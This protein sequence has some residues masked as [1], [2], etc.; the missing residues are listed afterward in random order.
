MNVKKLCEELHIKVL[1]CYEK[2]FALAM[3]E[4]EEKGTF[5]AED[6][7][8]YDVI[9]KYGIFEK[10]KN[11]LLKAA[12][13]IRKNKELLRF[14]YLLKHVLR[15][16]G[17]FDE[18]LQM[19]FPEND[20]E[21]LAFNFASLFSV[22]PLIEDMKARYEERGLPKEQLTQSLLE[23]ESKVDDFYSQYKKPGLK[24]HAL[25]LYKFIHGLILRVGRLN[26]EIFKGFDAYI[27]VFENKKGEHEILLSGECF[28]AEI[29]E[30]DTAYIGI[31][32]NP[33]DTQKREEITLL[34]SHWKPFLKRD[35]P[36][37]SVHIPSGNKLSPELCEQSYAKM[38][39]I[40]KDY[41]PDYKY[42]IFA[43]EHSW[44]ME[45]NLAD[46][47]SENSNILTFQ[48]KYTLYQNDATGKAVYD[49][50]FF[51][52]HSTPIEK[53]PEDTTLRRTIKKHYL[54]GGLILE[55]GGLI[56]ETKTEN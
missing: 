24:M 25:W 5:I 27:T 36:I 11:E 32:S 53:L 38:L 2:V 22:F 23:F 46:F 51:E 6:E 55:Q 3:V 17:V 16:E 39:T 31:R 18:I 12:G 4:F 49:F 13:G 48:R 10:W 33:Y 56:F 1:P 35:D 21:E 20:K 28:S 30:T 42:K 9:Q 43:C 14:A 26:F 45:P 29:K 44:L 7:R 40:L 19:E 8:V 50:L 15:A 47:L 54:S 52:P 34:K 37:V 41:Y